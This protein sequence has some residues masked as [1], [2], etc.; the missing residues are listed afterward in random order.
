[1]LVHVCWHPS[2]SL[3]LIIFLK[4]EW[5]EVIKSACLSLAVV[6]GA[7]YLRISPQFLCLAS[8]QLTESL[9]V[10]F[11]GGDRGRHP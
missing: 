8:L 11:Q 4:L 1:M 6:K 2:H 7:K 5:G 3:G 10:S 9:T